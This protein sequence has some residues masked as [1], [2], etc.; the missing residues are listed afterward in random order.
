MN[1]PRFSAQN[2]LYTTNNRYITIAYENTSPDS[3]MP[4][5]LAP[6]L[7]LTGRW[8]SWLCPTCC[9][10]CWEYGSCCL[11]CGFCWIVLANTNSHAS[12][13]R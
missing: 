5:Q 12:S 10:S 2:S 9:A 7:G 4:Q 11:T 6:G 3:V 13:F 1:M 8:P